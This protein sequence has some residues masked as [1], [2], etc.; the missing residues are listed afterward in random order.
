MTDPPAPVEPAP[1]PE[2]RRKREAGRN[3]PLAI[4]T[5]LLLAGTL[6]TTLVLSRP[7]FVGFLLVIVVLALL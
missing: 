1:S 7:A 2:P 4:V 6:L 5:A 3:L